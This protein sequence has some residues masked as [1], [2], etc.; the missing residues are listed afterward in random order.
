MSPGPSPFSRLLSELQRRRVIRVAVGYLAGAFVLLQVA[1]LVLPAL[2]LPEWSFRL[3]LALTA[4]GFP[5]ALG[6]AWAFDITPEGVRRTG[7]G[8][9]APGDPAPGDP[10][11]GANSAVGVRPAGAYLGLGVLVLLV[12]VGGYAWWSGPGGPGAADARDR[13]IAVLPF[14]SMAAEESNAYFASGVHEDILTELAM[15]RQLAVVS[16]TSV[17]GYAGT[18][19]PIPEIGR[20]LGVTH[21]LEGSVRKSGQ[22]VRVVAQLI[23][24][25]SDEHVWAAT[26]DRDVSDI[27]AVQ[28]EVAR[29][30]AAAMEAT[31]TPEEEARV[32]G[33]RPVDPEAYDLLLRARAMRNQGV[34][35]T[36]EAVRLTRRAIELDSELADAWGWLAA[37]YQDYVN[38][39]LGREWADSGVV[40]ARKAVTLD[41]GLPRAHTALAS[42]LQALGR[43]EAAEAS[44]RRALELQP[45][46]GPA[47]NNLAILLT[48]TGR[49]REGLPLFY[50]LARANPTSA[51]PHLNLATYMGLM[52]LEERARLH[53]EA[54]VDLAGER[55][56]RQIRD[57]SVPTYLGHLESAVAAGERMVA[58]SPR[59]PALRIDLALALASAG[60]WAEAR[61]HHDLVA[62]LSPGFAD[63]T[64]AATLVAT[65]DA[66]RGRAMAR[67]LVADL[68]LPDPRSLN[69]QD[70][71]QLI[72]SCAVAGDT[73]EAFRWLERAREMGNPAVAWLQV[74]PEL[75]SLR[76][77]ARFR[78]HVEAAERERAAVLAA[79]E[80]AGY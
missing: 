77:D 56:G 40:A 58:E 63:P 23:D 50:R 8:E 10:G 1:D 7:P 19:R 28:S 74:Q 48:L 46:D 4:L 47:L 51:Y 39:G 60:R 66:E 54:A 32:A 17:M 79:V 67:K 26:Y 24:A 25:R 80:A 75:A 29:A 52:G 65:G 41:P 27:F 11:Q 3:V 64:Y 45:D 22:R 31:L 78:A 34:G 21:I 38:L 43:T 5:V 72:Q 69:L 35:A 62:E 20:E 44:L 49:M 33:A 13:S 2:R 15:I 14:T 42:N 68:A 70:L 73:A 61:R 37:F 71:F 57:V 16:R 59:D 55:V 76:D 36:E 18:T 9:P 53:G 30:I 12:A 6:I